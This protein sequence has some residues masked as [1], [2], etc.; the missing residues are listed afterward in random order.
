M[1]FFVVVYR[2]VETDDNHV[3]ELLNH[4]LSLEEET[5]IANVSGEE[6]EVIGNKTTPILPARP[7]VTRG[8]PLS[9]ERWAQAMDSEGRVIDAPA[10]KK[11]IFRGVRKAEYFSS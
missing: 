2:P 8:P 10:I 11:I 9:V 6:Y 3:A 4:S 1:S 5:V 7:N